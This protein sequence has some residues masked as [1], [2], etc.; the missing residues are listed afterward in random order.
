MSLR[1]VQFLAVVF[2]ALALIPSGHICSHCRTRSIFRE[3][4][5]WPFRASLPAGRGSGSSTWRHSSSMS[6]WPSD[7]VGSARHSTSP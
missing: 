7:C 3:M 6:S 5:T 4:P 2:T 1:V